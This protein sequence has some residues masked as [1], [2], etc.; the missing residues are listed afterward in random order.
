MSLYDGDIEADDDAIVGVYC[1]S[2]PPPATLVSAFNHLFIA[3]VSGAEESG[4]GFVA[5]YRQSVREPS[6]DIPPANPGK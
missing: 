1:N 4:S 2:R 6:F 3:Q 5:E